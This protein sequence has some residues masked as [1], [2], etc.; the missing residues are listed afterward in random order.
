MTV[1]VA[2][3]YMNGRL[4]LGHA[5]TIMN[6][7][8]TYRLERQASKQLDGKMGAAAGEQ[9]IFPFGFHCTGMPIYASATRLE[10][11]DEGVR[12]SLLSMGID[13][14]ELHKFTDPAH[15][16]Y[17]F[18]EMAMNDLKDF[19]LGIN[20]T[21]SFVT[22]DINPYYNK[23]V[24]WQYRKLE[25]KKLLEYKKRPCVYS[26]KD[27]QPCADHDRQTGEGVKPKEFHLKYIGKTFLLEGK[28]TAEY[29]FDDTGH[30]SSWCY[31][32]VRSGAE[33]S[34]AEGSGAE[35]S[36]AEGF[37]PVYWYQNLLHQ[38]GGDVIK[39]IEM[40]AGPVFTPP[41]PLSKS[42][43][44]ITDT[45]LTVY[46][47]E[48]NVVSRTGDRCI[49]ATVP[50][51]YLRY[52]DSVWK[53][54]VLEHIRS[55]TI[56]NEEVRKQLLIACE[57]MDDWCVS[58]EYGLGTR[59]PCDSKFLI[60]SLSDSTI[61][62]AYYTVA[63]Q[64]HRDLY[65]KDEIMPLDMI[66]DE[67]FDRVL[68]G[69]YQPVT[70]VSGKDLI[71]NHLVM[72]IYHHIAIFGA[73]H[74]PKEYIINGFAKINGKKM[75]KSTGNFVTLRQALD[76]YSVDALKIML[77]EAGT[78]LED[79]NV[80]LKDGA[81]VQKALEQFYAT[82]DDSLIGLTGLT[83]LTGLTSV[84]VELDVYDRVFIQVLLDCWQMTKKAFAE[85][86][87]REA[88]VTGW[89]RVSKVTAQYIRLSGKTRLQPIGLNIQR[90][91]LNQVLGKT[92]TT[93]P[94][95]FIALDNMVL[96][97]EKVKLWDY[98]VSKSAQSPTITIHAKIA[99]HE[100]DIKEFMLAK[101]GFDCEIKLNHDHIHE[102]RDPFKMKY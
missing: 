50:Q 57:N 38:H 43:P 72:A 48:S 55:M 5:M 14:A 32:I 70:V 40:G 53:F 79:A 42:A 93:R 19:Q 4:H 95:Q 63:G 36:G 58:R 62:M 56:H 67:F 2:Y 37:I 89:R 25:S 13:P 45:G 68:P 11:G 91:T 99:R 41:T 18:P 10:H 64:L 88:L 24:Q 73:A 71:Y 59:L 102:K 44:T 27:G 69:A 98:L 35:G 16:V 21:R 26:L 28:T 12:D 75:A 1:V 87:Y 22:T 94:E 31:I 23:F 66:T 84:D 90:W 97:P 34:G 96:D 60:D 77:V 46:L 51:W 86:N 17:T 9:P 101:Y 6:A 82:C 20:W 81:N 52:S 33:G 74:A 61:Y 39:L 15:W 30:N 47:P 29:L 78:G 54:Q 8:I 7:E 92:Y 3:P 49:V 100:A 83:R 85:R 76:T 80:R 65:G